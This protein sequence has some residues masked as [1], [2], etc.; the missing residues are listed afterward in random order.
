MTELLR[1]G[2][3][4]APSDPDA[5]RYIHSTGLPAILERV[6]ASLLVTTYQLGKLAVFRARQ[7]KLSMLLRTFDKAMGV[8]VDQNR[9]AVGTRNSI[10]TLHN[11]PATA[12]SLDTTIRHDACFLPR[13]SHVTGDVSVHE[14][15]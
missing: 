6:Q 8:A 1:P 5:F 13:A 2:Y 10:W 15:A 7:E 4:P 12:E 11:D 3:S 14:M 9:M